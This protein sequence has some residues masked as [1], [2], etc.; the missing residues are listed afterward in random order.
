MNGLPESNVDQQLVPTAN[1]ESGTKKRKPHPTQERVKELFDYD[2]ET[3]TLT[4]RC[5]HGLT[6]VSG[7]VP[8]KLQSKEISNTICIDNVYYKLCVIIWLWYY[9][10]CPD[11]HIRHK[12]FN[13]LN[14]SIDNLCLRGEAIPLTQERVRFLLDYDPLTGIATRKVTTH[15]N[16][17]V[18]NVINKVNKVGY[19][20]LCID[21]KTYSLHRIIWLWMYGYLPENVVDHIDRCKINN[22][23]SNLREVAQSCN[24]KNSCLSNRNTSGVKGVSWDK[25][26]NAY[27]VSVTV[28]IKGIKKHRFIGRKRDFIEAVAHRLAAEECLD[29]PGCD[30]DSTA[31][32]H[33]QNYLQEL[34]CQKS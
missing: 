2:P 31:Y 16:S 24:A 23:I 12:D 19:I 15:Y 32:Q 5:N 18:G 3:G 8:R 22:E 11:K 27:C 7:D 34:K 14:N 17:K 21:G 10:V 9:G 4:W 30:N 28:T 29:W 6:G 26:K 1:P 20:T 13:S 33:M 25:S